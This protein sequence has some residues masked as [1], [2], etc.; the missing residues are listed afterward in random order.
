MNNEFKR[1]QEL[2]GLTTE[3]KV[4]VKDLIPGQKY[5]LNSEKTMY[6]TFDQYLNEFSAAKFIDIKFMEKPYPGSKMSKE[7]TFEKV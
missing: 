2:A 3:N 1:M 4:P 5:Y 6:G 7:S